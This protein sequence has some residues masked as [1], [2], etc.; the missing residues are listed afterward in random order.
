MYID[1]VLCKNG[2]NKQTFLFQ[3]PGF[4]RLSTGDE[5]ICDT[6]LG[7]QKMTVVEV[8]SISNATEPRAY[9]MVL[10]AAGATEPLKKVISKIEYSEFKYEEDEND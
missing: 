2:K 1:L 5:V 7:K 8:M 3:A 10:K 9:N 6:V 4:S